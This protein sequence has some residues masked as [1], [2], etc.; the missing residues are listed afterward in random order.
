LAATGVDQLL[1]VLA[2]P[3]RRAIV[4]MLRVGALRAGEIHAAFPIADPAISRHLRV[5]R[6]AGLVVERRVPADARVRL[7]ELAPSALAELAIWI[8]RLAQDQPVEVLL[9]QAQPAAVGPATS[10]QATTVSAQ[11]QLDAFR[12]YANVRTAGLERSPS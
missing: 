9:P 2:E 6:E 10:Q 1:A 5:L 11:A 8:N 4:D 7:Y 3:T 12:D